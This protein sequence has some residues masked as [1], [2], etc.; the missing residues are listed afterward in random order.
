MGYTNSFAYTSNQVVDLLFLSDKALK[1]INSMTEKE[2]SVINCI[3][4][5]PQIKQLFQLLSLFQ[6]EKSYYEDSFRYDFN[7][8]VATRSIEELTHN[9]YN[10]DD[11]DY[12]TYKDIAQALISKHSRA[13]YKSLNYYFDDFIDFNDTDL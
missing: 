8:L 1:H 3:L 2:R 12:F 10:I 4:E 13:I 7:E 6:N 11:S 5:Y 9:K